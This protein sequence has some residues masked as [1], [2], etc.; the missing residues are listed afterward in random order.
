MI[1]V[2]GGAGF[3]GSNI[4]AA[5][6]KQG[7]KDIVVADW[8]GCGDK[9]KNIAIRELAAVVAPEELFPF[10]AAH[11]DEITAVVHMGA[12]SAT[13]EKEVDLIIRSNYQLS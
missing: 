10:L 2:T 1:I 6:E 8:L 9:W 5:L 11:R 13:T 3:I 4:I 7:Y 12:I